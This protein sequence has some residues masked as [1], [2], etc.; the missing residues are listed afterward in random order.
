MAGEA[1]AEET[2]VAGAGLQPRGRSGQQAAAE[3]GRSEAEGRGTQVE[4]ADDAGESQQTTHFVRKTI[5][6]DSILS[7]FNTL[8]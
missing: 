4:D 2:G 1:D 8:V 3:E 6:G 7:N 5:S